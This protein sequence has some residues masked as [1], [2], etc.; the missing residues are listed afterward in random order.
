M[1]EHD[2]D[3]SL[4]QLSA[5]SDMIREYWRDVRA[6]WQASEASLRRTVFYF[7]A[8]A[9]GFI[10]LGAKG[11]RE[12][13]FVGLTVTDLNVVRTLIPVVMAYLAYVVSANAAISLRLRVL[14]DKLAEH[15]WNDLYKHNLELAVRPVGSFLDLAMIEN[16]IHSKALSS[17]VHAGNIVRFLVILAG[18]TLFEVFALWKLLAQG[19]GP[20]WLEIVVAFLSGLLV[21]ASFANLVYV[22]AYRKAG[23]PAP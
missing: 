3:E 19:G 23:N 12:I 16:H 15:Y 22:F 5:N 21:L 2:F 10:L 14:H 7:F 18:P 20:L 13:T 8:L 1:P 6:N 11:V 17:W 4:G 9:T